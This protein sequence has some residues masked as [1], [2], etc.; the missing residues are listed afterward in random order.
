MLYL[1]DANTLIDAKNFYWQMER[2]P[3]FWE[4]LEYQGNE[5]R[6]KI[7][8]Q[9]YDELDGGNSASPTADELTV[10]V[11]QPNIRTALLLDE[12]AEPDD[13]NEVVTNGYL[14]T[15]TAADLLAMGRDP[16]LISYG[17]KDVGNRTIVTTERSK[18]S[19]SGSK[20][21]VPDV[22]NSLGVTFIDTYQLT[23]DLDFR[24]SWK[25]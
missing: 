21:H 6:I 19:K 20:R 3:E 18:P 23:E 22:C 9:I 14:A 15:P 24:T 12:E 16:F 13:V 11:H 8:Q 2:V 10:W 17:Y 1:L 7:P 4:W 5:G 25:S